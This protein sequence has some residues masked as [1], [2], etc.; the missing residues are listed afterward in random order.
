MLSNLGSGLAFRG[1][2]PNTGLHV[3][4]IAGN[5]MEWAVVAE[6]CYAFNHVLIGIHDTFSAA[7]KST[8]L[9]RDPAPSIDVRSSHIFTHTNV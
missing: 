1:F 3:A 4:V 6:M 2:T 8:I 5:I 9:A 7:A